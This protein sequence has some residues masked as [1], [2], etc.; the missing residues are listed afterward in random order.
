MTV[1]SFSP[2]LFLDRLGR[3]KHDLGKYGREGVE[4]QGL[5]LIPGDFGALVI[6]RS[7]LLLPSLTEF[8]TFRDVISSLRCYAQDMRFCNYMLYIDES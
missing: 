4:T 1:F 8:L 5:L 2:F 7:V 6:E 3:D